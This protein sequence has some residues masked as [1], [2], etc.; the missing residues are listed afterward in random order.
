MGNLTTQGLMNL[1]E[2]KSGINVG[3]LAFDTAVG[4]SLGK[5]GCLAE[6]GLTF[7]RSEQL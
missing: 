4:F 2:R 7:G 3:S 5:F 1:S 6:E